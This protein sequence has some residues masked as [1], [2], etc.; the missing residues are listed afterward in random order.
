[1]S[2]LLHS[3]R[4]LDVDGQVDDG[5]LLFDGEEIVAAGSGQVPDADETVDIGG[6]WVVPG[7]VD[8]HCHGGGGFSVEDGPDA[9]DAALQAHRRHGTTRTVVSFVTA[10]L[11]TLL[12]NLDIVADLMEDDPLI[13]GAHLEGP[14]LAAGKRGVHDEGLLLEPDPAAVEQLIGAARGQLRQ[15]T[16]APELTNALESIDVL[17]EAGVAVAV[18]HTEATY[19]QAREA[20]DRGARMLTHAFNGMNGIHH[21]A[22]GPVVAALEDER[23]VL[24]LVLD[25]HHVA[26][27]VAALAL[28]AARHRVALISDAMA[29]A[30]GDDGDYSLGTVDV[31]VRDGLALVPG[32]STIAGSTLTLDRA[33]RAAI[34]LGLAP[35]DAV[36]ALTAVPARA[37]GIEDRFGRL[38]PGY[39]A[40]AVVL[41]HDWTVREVWADGKHLTA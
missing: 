32:T 17:V 1:M 22:P 21:R 34:T 39:V 31:A 9:L 16:I 33:L 36:A 18:G 3:A 41:A 35:K 26:P 10:P 38:A 15:I 7:F 28:H 30:G 27:P 6:A 24:E 29:A 14:F 12:D 11:A 5:W 4:L 23:V 2:V 19:E 37:L 8:L 40:D 20:F 13:L 25:G